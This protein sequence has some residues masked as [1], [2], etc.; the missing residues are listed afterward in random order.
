MHNAL[1]R[2]EHRGERDAGGHHDWREAGAAWGRSSVDWSC[3]YEHYAVEVIAAI[4]AR[5]GIGPGTDVLD[6]A[7]GAGLAIRHAS[8]NGAT[9]AGIDASES[10]VNIARDRNPEADIQLGSMFELPWP[11]ASLTSSSRSTASGAAA[12]TR[13]TRCDE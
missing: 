6:V 13:C 4:L 9:V 5:T 10:L 8:G 7:C 1:S 11:T 12:R 3:L 2:R